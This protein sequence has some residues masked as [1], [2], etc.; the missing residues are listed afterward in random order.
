MNWQVLKLQWTE[1]IKG[2]DLHT[3]W[4]YEFLLRIARH[5]KHMRAVS[6]DH[7]QRVIFVCLVQFP[8]NGFMLCSGVNK[9]LEGVVLVMGHA[10]QRGNM[11]G[12]YIY[13]KNPTINSVCP[14]KWA[15]LIGRKNNYKPFNIFNVSIKYYSLVSMNDFSIMF[16]ILFLKMYL[17]C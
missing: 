16:L 12:V 3:Y 13:L 2:L 10:K 9:S 6:C 1:Y 11:L 7:N 8:L 15:L 14:G 4:R 5:F 17:A